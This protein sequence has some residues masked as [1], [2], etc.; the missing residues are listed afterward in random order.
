MDHIL[1]ASEGHKVTIRGIFH[2]TDQITGETS[3]LKKFYCQLFVTQVY[4]I[5]K[6]A[7]GQLR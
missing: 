3:Q 6:L 4:Y 7:F 5:G 1:P 2:D